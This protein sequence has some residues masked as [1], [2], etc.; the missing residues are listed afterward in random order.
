[1]TSNSERVRDPGAPAPGRLQLSGFRRGA[2]RP[3]ADRRRSGALMA[4]AAN[5]YASGRTA[6][7]AL[8]TVLVWI[9]FY[10]DNSRFLSANNIA[11]LIDQIVPVGVLSVGMAVVLLSGEIDLSGAAVGASRPPWPP[12]SPSA[13]A[14]RPAWHC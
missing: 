8:V 6:A 1:M 13:T 3:G 14:C 11:G 5:W 7:I 12:G 2:D 10:L 9:G 4:G